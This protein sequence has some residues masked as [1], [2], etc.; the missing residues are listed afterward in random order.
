M[1]EKRIDI[2]NVKNI[3]VNGYW[4]KIN[5]VRASFLSSNDKKDFFFIIEILNS[6]DNLN[7]LDNFVNYVR[8][9]RIGN[10]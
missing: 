6:L 3:D 2:I 1:G 5:E 8:V 10:K 9:I 7:T 4:L